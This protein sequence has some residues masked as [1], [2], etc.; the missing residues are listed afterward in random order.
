V[1]AKHHSDTRTL[2]GCRV[3]VQDEKHQYDMTGAM[4]QAT[5]D[6]NDPNHL[7]GQ[8]V[9]QTDGGKMVITWDLRRDT[10]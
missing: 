8:K 10:E 1:P 4:I 6:P 9:D 7:A 3:V 5:P 2:P